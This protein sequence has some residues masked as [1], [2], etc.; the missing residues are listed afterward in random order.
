[1]KIDVII[2]VYKPDKRLFTIIERLELQSIPAQRIIIMNTEEKYFEQ[3]TYGTHFFD[4]HKRVRV[5]HLSKREFDHGKTRHIAVQK[6]DA[7]IFIMMTQ[8]AVPADTELI[9][10]LVQNL[11]GKTAVSYGRQLPTKNSN[12][13]ENYM[14]EFNYPPQSRIKTMEDV[15]E[16]GIKTY[17]CSNVC[18]AYRRDV[19]EELGGFVRHIIFNEDMIYAAAAI[20]AGYA[21]SYEA[22]ARVYHSHNY[23]DK[24]QFHRNFD[25]G[26]SQADHPEVFADAPSESEGL[27]SVRNAKAY[28]KEN[29]LGKYVTRLYLQS[30]YKYAG[31][32]LGKHYKRLPRQWVISMSLNKEYW[33]REGIRRDLEGIDPSKGYGRSEAEE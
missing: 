3:L 18:A 17:F 27:K 1:M 28:L 26:V 21:V 2:P 19:Y 5:Y 32:F 33:N 4:K 11:Q 25:L 30:A 29:N 16:L 12:V 20:H 6:S 10:R 22:A 7:E 13:I 9:R 15:P 23:T 14:R 24:Q 8:D 31:Y